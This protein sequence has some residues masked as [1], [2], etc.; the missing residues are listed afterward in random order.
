MAHITITGGSGAIATALRPHLTAAGHHLTLIDLTPP[1]GELGE[2]ETHH[3]AS[4]IDPQAMRTHLAHSD[5]VVHLGGHSGERPWHDIL[6][7]N[8]DGAHTILQAAH[9]CGISRVLLASSIHAVGYHTPASIAGVA[10]P[11]ARPDTYYGM[12]KVALE[13]LGQ[14]YADR[15]PMLIVSARLGTAN[16]VPESPRT[17]HTWVSTADIARLV[18]ATLTHPGLG[19]H[20]VW[21]MSN[22]TRSW[23]DQRAG[24]AIGYQP[25]DDAETYAA[26]LG[27][28]APLSPDTLLA[29]G[30]VGEGAPLGGAR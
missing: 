28:P 27:N 14:L 17:L 10:V 24:Q 19:H 13:A 29:G 25:L 22:N 20:I 8:I 9:D 3:T 15:Y 6:S 26:A 16:P 7:T 18:T 23:F 30:F 4:I 21:G 11:D 5:L 2:H 1:P 12:S